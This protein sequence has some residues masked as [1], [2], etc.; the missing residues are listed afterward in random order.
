MDTESIEKNSVRQHASAD[1]QAS[2]LYIAFLAF[3]SGAGVIAFLVATLYKSHLGV[4]AVDASVLLPVYRPLL[5]P[6][7]VERFTFLL[8]ASTLPV[9]AFFCSLLVSGSRPRWLPRALAPAIGAVVALGFLV[10]F[11]RFGFDPSLL[12]GKHWPGTHPLLLLC[13]T[14]V[15]AVLASVIPIKAPVRATR[16]LTSFIGWS[17]FFASAVLQLVAWRIVNVNSITEGNTWMSMDAVVYSVSQV[18]AGRTLLVDLPSQYGLFP[19]FIAPFFRLVGLSIFSF[20]ALF[21]VMQMVS[22]GSVYWVAQRLLRHPLFRIGFGIALVMVTYETCLFFVGIREQYFQYWPVRFFWPAFS[23]FAFYRYAQ[24]P[25]LCRAALMSSIGAIAS[26]WNSDS[27]VMVELAFAAFL[28]AK[29]TALFSRDRSQS[30]SER[31]AILLKL[32]LHG[33]VFAVAIGVAALYL[34]IK[35]DR[36]FHWMW[37]IGYQKLFYGLGFMMLPLPLK[38]S[39]WMAV[40]GVYLLG[41]LV[42]A[43]T[44]RYSPRSRFADVLLYASLLG[45]GLF[46]YYEGRSHILNLVTVSWPALLAASLMADRLVRATAVGILRRTFMAPAAVAGGVIL[47]CCLAFCQGI[48]ALG[49]SARSAFA[50]WSIPASPVV[51]DE[52]A[53]ISSHTRKGDACV[54]LSKRQGLYYASLHLF[55]PLIGPGYMETLTVPDRDSMIAQLNARKFDC[56]FIGQGDSAP[57]LG[58]DLLRALPSYRVVRSNAYQTMVQ[59]SPT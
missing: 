53:F 12:T 28:F 36:S 22:L 44:W 16:R 10:Q 40:L 23:M 29:W 37:L 6:K 59:L 38:A 24:K 8:L 13:C 57:A 17:L 4:H 27:G 25:S 32:W 50:N 45:V 51:H 14:V 20:S 48:P 5:D 56:V 49:N 55:S 34:S 39:P 3:G 35:A 15:A 52:I 58:I 42:A 1:D 9:V 43:S 41:I 33:V 47:L 31:R 54:I 11:A 26:L 18:F 2:W 19:E 30:S 21:A 46:I 7:P